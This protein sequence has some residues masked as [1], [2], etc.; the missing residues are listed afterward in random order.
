M[1]ISKLSLPRRTFLRGVGAT[2]ALPLLDAMVPAA[3]ALAQTPAKP[4]L[5]FGAVMVPQGAVREA[6]MPAQTGSN[7]DFSPTLKPLEPFRDHVV[8][9]SGTGQTS[10]DAGHAPGPIVFLTGVPGKKTEMTDVRAG[11][12]LD[13]VFAKA[14]GQTTTFPSIE[15][16]T[17]DFSGYVG[18]CDNGWACA[19]LNT[20]SWADPTT[21]LPMEVNPRVVFERLFGGA[22]TAEQR[23]ARMRVGRSVLDSIAPEATRLRS[24]LGG[25]DQEKL[26]AYLANVRE[27]ERRLERAEKNSNAQV[28]LDAPVGV[29]TDFGE[30][31][32]LMFDMLHVAFQTDTTRVFT[33]QMA[34]ELSQRIYPEIGCLDPHHAMSHHRNE[35]L[36]L[37]ANARLQ[38]YHYSLFAA[39]VE[40]LKATPDGDGT[41]LD[42]VI[43]QYGSGMSDSNAHSHHD[44]P[45][46]V[47]GGGA[48]TIKGNRHLAYP[49]GTPLAN[50]HVAYAHKLGVDLERFGDSNGVIDL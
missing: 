39:F 25:R 13:Q 3:T 31:V 8:V 43:L 35:P 41:L 34:R 20:I 38:F 4:T 26:D 2:L 14:I 33:F 16:A 5:R 23:L 46:V 30:H 12:S 27:I 49:L 19:Y 21:P 36:L 50:L 37:A 9:V 11:V 15:V 32:G 44:L 1:F 22:G 28:Q 17:E 47:V 40:K 42:H 18:A 6:W 7:F 48:G 10:A 24:G 29:P 45:I